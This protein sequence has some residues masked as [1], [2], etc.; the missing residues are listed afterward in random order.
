[1]ETL[2][3]FWTSQTGKMIYF[4]TLLLGI[5]LYISLTNQPITTYFLKNSVKS[6]TKTIFLS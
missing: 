5:L 2:F 4:S 3:E 6:L 1:M